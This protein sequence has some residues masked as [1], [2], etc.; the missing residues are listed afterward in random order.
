[1]EK[2][3]HEPVPI[4]ILLLLAATLPTVLDAPKSFLLQVENILRHIQHL[5]KNG[6]EARFCV[7][8]KSKTKESGELRVLDISKYSDKKECVI[9]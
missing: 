6:Y 9:R 3:G 5:I 7:V 1:M 4:G 2:P 8:W